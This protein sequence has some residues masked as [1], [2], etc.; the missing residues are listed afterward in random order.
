MSCN[1]G[2]QAKI[3]I[4]PNTHKYKTT[5]A[6]PTIMA[7]TKYNAFWENVFWKFILL[8]SYKRLKKAEFSSFSVKPYTFLGTIKLSGQWRSLVVSSLPGNPLL[9]RRGGARGRICIHD[10]WPRV[11]KN[12]TFEF[13]WICSASSFKF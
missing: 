11:S 4:F 8:Y 9:S 1:W 2:K 7:C 10:S 13:F 6:T 12:E 5:K 3:Y